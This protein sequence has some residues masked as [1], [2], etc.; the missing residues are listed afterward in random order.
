MEIEG[1]QDAPRGSEQSLIAVCIEADDNDTV[2]THDDRA[3]DNAGFGLHERGGADVV[4]HRCFFR[5]GQA[6]PGHPGAVDQLF[7]RHLFEPVVQRRCIHA[8]FLVVM[9]FV[10][11]AVLVQPGAGFFDGAAVWDAVKFHEVLQ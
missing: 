4:R 9:E 1:T 7:P 5:I 3:A 10:G 2:V 6:A 11:D 8:L